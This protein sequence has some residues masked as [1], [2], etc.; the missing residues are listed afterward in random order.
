MPVFAFMGDDT[1]SQTKRTMLAGKRCVVSSRVLDGKTGRKIDCG[2][3]DPITWKGVRLNFVSITYWNGQL[4]RAVGA[5]DRAR[6]AQVRARLVDTYGKP[7]RE[8]YQRMAEGPAAFTYP[9]TIW[10][11]D[12]GRLELESLTDDA[13]VLTFAFT[14][15]TPPEIDDVISLPV[16]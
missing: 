4:I 13:A 15:N 7:Q 6:H 5:F 14:L 10:E 2:P 9:E 11:F 1:A 12:G 16:P 8:G 3:S